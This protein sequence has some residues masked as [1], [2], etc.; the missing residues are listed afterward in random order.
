[1]SLSWPLKDLCI[2][3]PAKRIR[4]LPAIVHGIAVHGRSPPYGE[5]TL[6]KVKAA[7]DVLVL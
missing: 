5:D 1:M 3:D 7:N 4:K 6:T 2:Q